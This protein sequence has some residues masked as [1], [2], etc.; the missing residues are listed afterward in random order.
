MD[1]RKILIDIKGRWVDVT[2]ESTLSM[3]HLTEDQFD[4][5]ENGEDVF[6][7]LQDYNIPEM[8]MDEV[9]LEPLIEEAEEET[10]EE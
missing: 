1:E 10:I 9:I 8:D 5:L 6:Q 7:L 2:N 3:A 4:R